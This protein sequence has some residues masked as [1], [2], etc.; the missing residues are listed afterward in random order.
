M[1]MVTV[2]VLVLQSQS[3]D[4]CWGLDRVDQRE[5]LPYA[6]PTNPDAVYDW[7]EDTGSGVAVYV[8]DTGRFMKDICQSYICQAM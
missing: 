8:A 6:D 1:R 4:G 5:A 3:A 7:G 2:V